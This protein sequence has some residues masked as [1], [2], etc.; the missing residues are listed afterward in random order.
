MY[1]TRIRVSRL[2]ASTTLPNSFASPS[3][4]G[5]RPVSIFM[6]V[7]LPQPLE[8]RKP[9]IS[10]RSIV[11][12]TALTAVNFPKRRVR[13]LAT[14]AG[15]APV[16]TRGG[17]VSRRAPPRFSSGNRATK[18]SSRFWAPVRRLSSSGV[19][20]GQDAAG[21]HRDEPVEA[22]RLR[23][24]TRSRRARS[25]PAARPGSGRSASRTVAARAGRRRSSAR[26][27]SAGRGRES[28]TNRARPSASCRPRASRPAGPGT[29][30]APWPSG[31]RR[32]GERRSEPESPNSW[33]KKSMFS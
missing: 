15:S 13:F 7:D 29:G 4:A 28:A 31:V 25:S 27:G 9:K 5:R 3:V 11:K 1:P 16:S 8:P 12:F 24:C 30:R 22:A 20:D 14:M 18:V 23:P 2:F 17:M 6:V 32:S 26:R 19:P 33:A 10:P 21:I